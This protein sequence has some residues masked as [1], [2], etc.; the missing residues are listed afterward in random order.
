M[1]A[2]ASTVAALV[3]T[4]TPRDGGGW[5]S[6]GSNGTSKVAKTSAAVL[7]ATAAVTAALVVSYWDEVVFQSVR[8][9][10]AQRKLYHKPLPGRFPVI[11]DA[12]YLAKNRHRVHDVFVE[13]MQDHEE[14]S[15]KS[16]RPVHGGL[17]VPF[18]PASLIISD[19]KLIEHVLK[20]H[21]HIYEKGPYFRSRAFDL[22]G[23]GIFASDGESWR[24]QR[25]TSALIFNVRN[26]REFV[27]SVFTAEFERLAARLGRAADTGEV[28]DL[29]DLFFRFTLD[30]FCRIGFGEHLD[31]LDRE[32][33]PAFSAAFDSAQVRFVRRFQ[34]PLWWL[35]E[36][37]TLIAFTHRRNIG[38]IKAFGRSIVQR[39][40]D[41]LKA[42]AAGGTA[43][44]AAPTTG[45]RGSLGT[46]KAGQ[47]ERM[48]LLQLL[49]TSKDPRTG[50]EPTV[51]DLVDYVI[52]F[53]LAGRDTTALALSWTFLML[54]RNPDAKR[55]LVA[56]IDATFPASRADEHAGYE[57]IRGMAYANAVF[58]ETL[59]LYPPVPNEIKQANADDV[60]PNGVEVPRGA[61]V[62]WSNYAMGRSTRIW[63]P[64]A[65]KF[66]PERW[67]D[68]SRPQPSAFEYPVFNAGPRICLG[69]N[70]AEI[71]G[72]FV[73]VEL[74]RRF[75]F[76][77]IDHESVTYALSVTLPMK[78]G[79]RVRLT[80]RQPAA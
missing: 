66:L 37:V 5:G 43:S 38:V 29:Y 24:L 58:H 76:E 17:S 62:I 60:L 12:P 32:R 8:F 20:T 73:M 39:R 23:H 10:R 75:D 11:G 19:P 45:D 1:S 30:S 47:T 2:I 49:M 57:D 71:E 74:L 35:V 6:G 25:K 59:R 44:G 67:L 65:A 68:E 16:G 63:G 80:R 26:F 31:S 7:A 13:L 48:D 27:S 46:A 77:V 52:N 28:V 34:T 14:L 70:M 33:P 78:N 54:H 4:M 55:A 64:D 18:Q 53:I 36:W 21:F 3:A 42:E 15:E 79:M 40:L 9:S 61:L 72:V 56:E 41:E 69:K 22:L 51:D 50:R